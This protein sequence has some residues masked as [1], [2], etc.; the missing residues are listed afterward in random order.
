MKTTPG[1]KRPGFTLIEILMAMAIFSLVMTAIYS[2][3][4]AIIRGSQAGLKAAAEVQRERMVMHTLEQ[5]LTAVRLFQ[6]DPS[7]SRAG[8]QPDSF[9]VENGSDAKLSF[10]ARLP[11][12]FP[13]SG[14]F[15]DFAVR[16]VEFALR[17]K[18]SQRQLVLRQWPVLMDPNDFKDE[19]EN[20]VVLAKNVEELTF[21]LWVRGATDWLDT[22]TQTNQLPDLVKVTL[23]LATPRQ[24]SPTTKE[25]LIRTISLPCKAVPAGLRR[26]NL[27]IPNPPPNTQLNPPL[28][29][30]ARITRP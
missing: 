7:L 26:R 18:D 6:A 9:V 2:T 19:I 16:H 5:A 1:P 13:R 20:P 28:N 14:R 8:A 10:V 30:P 4:M 23:R 12:S 15:G 24:N 3:W 21:D 27:A 29:P 11:K 22:W 17:D 25:E